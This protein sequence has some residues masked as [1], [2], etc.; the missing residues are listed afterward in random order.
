MALSTTLSS[1]GTAAIV[2]NPIAKSTTVIMS[3]S[4]ASS[5][6]GAQIEMSLD[7]PTI[8]GGPVATWALLSSASGMVA[9]SSTAGTTTTVVYTV[10]S[11]I[12][13]VRI[14]SSATAA[15]SNTWTLKAL[16]SITA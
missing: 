3:A 14:N 13:Q 5:N 9:G 7:D 6:S 12:A 10:L 11:P 16:Q 1:V 4:V 8:P 2:L 15:S